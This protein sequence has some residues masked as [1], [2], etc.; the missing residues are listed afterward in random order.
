MP[1]LVGDSE[2]AVVVDRAVLDTGDI[3]FAEQPPSTSD[4][5]TKTAGQTD[6]ERFM[7]RV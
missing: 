2:T 1:G 3:G 4:T 7:R 5:P 6:L